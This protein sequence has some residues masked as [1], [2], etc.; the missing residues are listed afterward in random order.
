MGNAQ[1]PPVGQPQTRENAYKAQVIHKSAVPTDSIGWTEQSLFAELGDPR[2][3]VGSEEQML[4]QVYVLENMVKGAVH[5]AAVIAKKFNVGI[6]VRGTNVRSHM[7]IESGD[8]TKAQEFKNKTANEKDLLLCDQ[9]TSQDLG[10]VVHFDPRKGWKAQVTQ[11]TGKP[12]PIAPHEWN[13]KRSDLETRLPII[14]TDPR[15]RGVFIPTS[16]NE[17]ESLKGRFMQRGKEYGD[18]HRSYVRGGKYAEHAEIVGIHVRLKVQGG[19]ART[20]VGD[21]DLFGFT[22]LKENPHHFLPD[23]P[24]GALIDQVQAALQSSNTFQAQHGG[25]WYWN[26]ESDKD[27]DIR[28]KIMGNH[29][30]QDDEPLLYFSGNWS[31]PVRAVFY[32]PGESDARDKVESVWDHPGSQKWYP[33][34]PKA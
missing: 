25:I 11:S 24:N 2:N 16:P 10:T 34:T 21:H 9:M 8:P 27:K 18:E 15:K 6:A 29:G 28:K 13:A 22:S 1:K 20:M 17:W 32:V 7:G 26:P 31:R 30:S 3:E 33:Y 19:G 4:E 5:E 12:L 23:P 14:S